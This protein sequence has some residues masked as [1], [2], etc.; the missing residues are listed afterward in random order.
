[1]VTQSLLSSLLRLVSPTPRARGPHHASTSRHWT[2][3]AVTHSDDFGAKLETVLQAGGH[4]CV[5]TGSLRRAR[6]ALQTEQPEIAVIDWRIGANEARDTVQTLRREAGIGHLP[7]LAAV[8][9]DG[10]D[11][12]L[13]SSNPV[14]TITSRSTESRPGS[15]LG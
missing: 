8:G 9:E 14:S 2:V 15:T 7:I 10:H 12:L 6:R 3:L 1:M 4:R 5:V 11:G 13:R